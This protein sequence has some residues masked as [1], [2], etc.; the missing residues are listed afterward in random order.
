M[1]ADKR[2]A[3]TRAW[4]VSIAAAASLALFVKL[5]LALTSEGSADVIGFADHLAKIRELG[6]TGVY[7]VKGPFNNPFNSPPFIVHALRALGFLADST[8]LKFSFWLRLPAILADIGS[9]FVVWKILNQKPALLPRSPVLHLLLALCPISIMVSG[10]HGNTDPLMVF[11]ALLAIYFIERGERWWLAGL[12]FGLALDIKVAPLILAPAICFYLPGTRARLQYFGAAAVVFISSSVPY[13][14]SDPLIL[15]NVFGYSSLYGQWGWSALLERWY[16]EAPRFLNPPH[17]VVG[18]HAVFASIGKWVMLL[19]IAGASY[20][21]NRRATKPPLILQCGFIVTLFLF[22]TPGFGIQ[23]LSWLVPLVI[24]LDVWPTVFFYLTASVYQ[25][26]GYTCW[27][28]RDA[29]PHFCLERDTALW[30]MILC[31]GS[32]LILLLIYHRRIAA[33]R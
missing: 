4:L 28:L 5:Y 17:D 25:L 20:W 27:G 30:V 9:L 31:W 6:G 7:Y 19:S 32:L 26:M 14:L 18:I 16:W 22:L 3:M 2:A 13:I 21:M 8:P 12:V 33:R 11:L 10:Y 1:T 15:K 24:A 29:P 23:Y